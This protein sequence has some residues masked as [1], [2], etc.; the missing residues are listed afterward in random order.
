MVAVL[1]L[2]LSSSRQNNLTGSKNL[3]DSFKIITSHYIIISTLFCHCHGFSWSCVNCDFACISIFFT[4]IVP[5]CVPFVFCHKDK[6]IEW[7]HEIYFQLV[8]YLF[9]P[10]TVRSIVDGFFHRAN[11]SNIEIILLVST[12][13]SSPRISMRTPDEAQDRSNAKK[14]RGCDIC[15]FCTK[16]MFQY[17]LVRILSSKPPNKFFSFQH[18]G[19]TEPNKIREFRAKWYCT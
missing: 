14:A 7:D 5:Y 2:L 13:L 15:N 10:Y 6:M 3:S 17:S 18:G 8:S 9:V 12:S 11:T 4:L 19:C 1:Y 16:F